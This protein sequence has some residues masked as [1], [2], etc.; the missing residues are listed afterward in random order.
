MYD[1]AYSQPSKKVRK[2]NRPKKEGVDEKGRKQRKQYTRW[3]TG[4]DLY[5]DF[6]LSIPCLLAVAKAEKSS[7][8][9]KI[10]YLCLASKYMFNTLVLHFSLLDLFS[11]HSLLFP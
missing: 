10:G 3:T 11:V 4:E 7:K 8:Y 1:V 2:S 5:I 6:G 9:D